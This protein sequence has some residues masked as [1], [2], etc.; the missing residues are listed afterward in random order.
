MV[1]VEGDQWPSLARLNWLVLE[2][3][4]MALRVRVAAGQFGDV[5][6]NKRSLLR[7]ELIPAGAPAAPWI[8]PKP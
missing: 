4:P 3:I 8:C 2:E 7:S 5:S 1:V 6:G